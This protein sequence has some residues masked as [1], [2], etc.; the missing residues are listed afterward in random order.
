[1]TKAELVET[2]SNKL[3]MDRSS[4]EKSVN[5]VLDGIIEALQQGQRVVISGFGAFSVSARPA[6]SGRNPET[7]EPIHLPASRSAKF[8]AGKQ[9]KE[10]L[11]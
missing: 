9:L 2:L 11:N 6:R 5:I 3:P 8:K 10:S 7:G 4:A 1:M